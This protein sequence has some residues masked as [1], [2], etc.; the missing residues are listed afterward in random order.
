M[1]AL[2]RTLNAVANIE[3]TKIWALALF[4]FSGL[5]GAEKWFRRG[6]S[7]VAAVS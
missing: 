5:I 1:L 4:D 6:S 3:L 2:N 7:D